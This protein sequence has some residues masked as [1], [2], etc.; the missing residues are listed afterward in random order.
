MAPAKQNFI[1]RWCQMSTWIHTCILIWI[2]LMSNNITMNPRIIPASLNVFKMNHRT[3]E[4]QASTWANTTSKGKERCRGRWPRR[5]KDTPPWKWLQPLLRKMTKGPRT[6]RRNT[7]LS[8]IWQKS[9]IGQE[10]RPNGCTKKKKKLRNRLTKR[11]LQLFG[12]TCKNIHLCRPPK[13]LNKCLKIGSLLNPSWVTREG[14]SPTLLA[15]Q[16]M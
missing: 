12:H 5:L 10:L 14:V 15:S 9:K 1:L 11:W 6:S 8:L 16:R 2:L 4:F 13:K 7:E 3:R